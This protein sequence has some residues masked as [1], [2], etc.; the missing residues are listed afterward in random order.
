MKKLIEYAKM[1]R[2]VVYY[3]YGGVGIVLIAALAAMIGS[4]WNGVDGFNGATTPA[5]VEL[6]VAGIFISNIVAFLSIL[7]SQYKMKNVVLKSVFGCAQLIS[8]S[9]AVVV[10]IAHIENI[11]PSAY[12][13][14]PSNM[15]VLETTASYLGLCI[16]G[17][18]VLVLLDYA[19][20]IIEL[21]E[22]RK[23]NERQA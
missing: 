12:I 18:M 11:I 10:S 7:V 21:F 15:S 1:V 14:S 5:E 23:N 22:K 20:Y 13:I 17:I 2:D 6:I 3:A 19:V 16:I 9:A 8:L 4:V